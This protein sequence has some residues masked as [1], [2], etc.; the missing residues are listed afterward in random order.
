MCTYVCVLT[1][2]RRSR[3]C[4]AIRSRSRGEVTR[5]MT[6]NI[7]ATD[8][9]QRPPPPLP[10]SISFLFLSTCKAGSLF[11][12]VSLTFVLVY[13]APLLVWTDDSAEPSTI[14]PR[15]YRAFIS[16]TSARE[17]GT[18]KCVIGNAYTGTHSRLFRLYFL[19]SRAPAYPDSY[20]FIHI[21]WRR[22]LAILITSKTSILLHY[23][24]TTFMSIRYLL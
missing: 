23:D 4:I 10:L 9:F 5:K 2:V 24:Y 19:I 22:L 8:I 6:A 12:R 17:R 20:S 18:L 15:M 3:G 16:V 11:L 7:K 14:A 21:H 1:H 13:L